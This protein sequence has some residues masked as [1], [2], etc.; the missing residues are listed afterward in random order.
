MISLSAVQ[1]PRRMDTTSEKDVQIT[2]Q[3]RTRMKEYTSFNVLEFIKCFSTRPTHH[4]DKLQ[5]EVALAVFFFQK[6]VAQLKYACDA[7]MTRFGDSALFR[8]ESESHVLVVLVTWPSESQNP[9]DVGPQPFSSSSIE[10]ACFA[11]PPTKALARPPPVTIMN[12]KP[13]ASFTIPNHEPRSRTEEYVGFL[14]DRIL[15]LLTVLFV[16]MSQML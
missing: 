14:V 10:T 1:T 15:C 3:H 6:K 5:L 9:G 13:H 4:K 7:T 8:K 2:N 16:R 11:L 12:S